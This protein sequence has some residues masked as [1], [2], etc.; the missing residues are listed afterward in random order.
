MG[1][2]MAFNLFSKQ[3]ALA[4]DSH[5]VV[6]DAVPT[7]A[8]RFRDA[9]KEQFPGA[10]CLPTAEE[11]HSLWQYIDA[12]DVFSVGRVPYDLAA[13]LGK[14]ASAASGMEETLP[15][16]LGAVAAGRLTLDDI[17]LRSLLLSDVGDELGRASRDLRV[18]Q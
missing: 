6:C 13:Q 9:F 17:R 18:R 10:S 7:S 11:Q 14:E 2:E 16:L 1:Y 5:F 15:L 12:I 4:S 8:A 3:H